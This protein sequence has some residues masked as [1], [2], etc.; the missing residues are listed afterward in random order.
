MS[1]EDVQ[2]PHNVPSYPP[3]DVE[4]EAAKQ[5]GAVS[6]GASAELP[7]SSPA[8]AVITSVVPDSVAYEAGFEPGC[9]ITALNG[10]PLRDIIDW[11]WRAGGDYIELGYIDCDGEAG[12]ITLERSD[13]TPWGFEFDQLV[14][15]GVKQC[16]NACSFCFMRQLPA[17]MRDSLYLR[18]DDYRLSFL[19][20]TFVTLTNLSAADEARIIEQRLS[21]LRVSLHAVDPTVRKTLMGVHAQEGLDAFERLLAAGVEAHVQIVLVPGVN[22][23]EVLQQTLTW[24]YEHPGI[25][26]V[27]IVPLGYTSHQE[28][29]EAGI[30][31]PWQAEEVLQLIEPFQ[32]RAQEERGY[33]WVYAADEIYL[34]AYGRQ[35]F[36]KLPPASFYGSFDMFE[37]GIGIVRSVLDEWKSA[38]ELGLLKQ[39]GDH[40]AHEG[41][42][43]LQV[44]GFAPQAYLALL[45]RHKDLQGQLMP[46]Y[47]ENR[48]FGGNVDV[49]GLLTGQD[50]IAALQAL[51]DVHVVSLTSERI[52]AL[53]RVMFNDNG[54]TLDGMTFDDIAQALSLPVTVVSCSPKECFQELLELTRTAL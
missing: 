52:V 22:D 8:P 49:T 21:P 39:V 7:V 18:D 28:M 10:K 26:S 11:Q 30:D 54:L 23:G 12:T 14:F 3:R 29:F 13:G 35:V 6:Q 44:S 2:K 40:L 32:Q 48:Y 4:R 31:R 53:P 20:G 51:E 15:D 45:A 19:A 34:T 24:A 25:L 47:V 50:V 38:E 17:G 27:G 41:L 33:G 36:E 9:K 42:Q 43:V 46:Y 1:G 37:D 5:C 16:R